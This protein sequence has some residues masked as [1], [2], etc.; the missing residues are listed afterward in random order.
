MLLKVPLVSVILPLTT[1]YSG[2]SGSGSGSSEPLDE[3]SEE[4]S[5]EFSVELS[6]EL[7]EVPV[8]EE[9]AGEE[10]SPSDEVIEE[11]LVE[12]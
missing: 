8:L 1:L 9:S 6:L 10:D 4:L 3:L 11:S 7:S 12:D 2:S 5:E